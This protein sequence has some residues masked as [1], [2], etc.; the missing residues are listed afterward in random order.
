[1]GTRF[2]TFES[3]GL[4]PNGRLYAGDLNQ[5][6]DTYADQMNWS[7]EVDAASYGIG[8]AALQLLRYGPGEARISGAMR[9]DGIFR[10]LGGLFAGAF[11]TAQRDAIAAGRRPY[12]LIILNS[13]TNQ[14][15]WN[16]GSDATPQWAPMSPPVFEV[17]VGAVMDWPWA[18]ATAPANTVIP[19]GQTISRA[20]YPALH[21]LAQ[22][23]GYPY[24][25]GDGSTTFG[26]PDYRGRVGIGKDDMGGTAANRITVGVSGINGASLGAIGG[27]EGVTITTGMMPAHNHAITDNGHIHGVTDGQHTHGLNPGSHSHSITDVQHNHGVNNPSHNHTLHD[28]THGH[29]LSQGAHGHNIGR[30]HSQ[31]GTDNYIAAATGQRDDSYNGVDGNTIPISVNGGGTG[32][33]IDAVATAVSL[34]NA[35]SGIG[36]TNAQGASGITANNATSNVSVNNGTTGVTVNN[37]GGGAA[38]ANVQPAVIV[39]K[40]LRAV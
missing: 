37:A 12:G 6:Q 31:D 40:L 23:S 1:M 20:A 32:V 18:A 16:K 17:P 24:G 22:G 27:A 33:Y 15:E 21:A 30:S 34:N 28:P 9:I 2:K 5:L 35:Y 36:G 13:Q 39:N 19:F 38:H 11:T 26:V 4:A 14:Y 10:G 3:T 25:N 29:G 8:E 7:Q